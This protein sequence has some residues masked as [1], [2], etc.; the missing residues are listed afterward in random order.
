MDSLP[1]AEGVDEAGGGAAFPHAAPMPLLVPTCQG[2]PPPLGS[3]PAPTPRTP[4]SR[5]RHRRGA[6][7]HPP[8]GCE[9]RPCTRA[10][11]ATFG[12]A[13]AAPD[14]RTH[15]VTSRDVCA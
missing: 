11:R 1:A 13:T 14:S 9:H 4:P 10:R 12:A 15:P 6:L 5:A 8:S 7:L 2:W 3:T